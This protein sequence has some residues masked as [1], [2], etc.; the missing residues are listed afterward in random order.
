MNHLIEFKNVTLGYGK[1]IIL[2]NLN[3]SIEKGD[4]LGLVGPNGAGKTTVLR[5]I[6]GTLK[7]ISG[8]ILLQTNKSN[9]TTFGYVPQRD[10]IDPIMPYTVEDIVMMGRYSQIDIFKSPNSNDYQL[11]T[12][13]LQQVAIEDLRYQSFKELSGGQKQRALI[14]RALISEPEILVLD[15]PTSGMDL[16]SR[17]SILSLIKQLHTARYTVILV[18]HLLSDVANTA[19]RIAFIEKNYFQVGNVTDILTS[20]NL[21]AKYGIEVEVIEYKDKKIVITGERHV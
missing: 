1:K 15:E 8:E 5:S 19:M 6:I 4:F 10:L 2:S 18:S 16:S 14:A 3:F 13:C 17:Q 9:R 20:E 21:S 11:L 7:P 12:K